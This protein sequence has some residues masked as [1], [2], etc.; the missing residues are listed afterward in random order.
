M[1]Y[2]EHV[3]NKGNAYRA[4][5][6]KGMATLIRIDKNG[7]KYWG[8]SKC[9]KCGGTGRLECYAHVEA[10]ICFLCDGSGIHEHRW[11]EY[12]PEYAQKLADR[13]VAKWRKEAPKHNEKLWKSIGL[14]EDGSAW[15]VIN[16]YAKAIDMKPQGAHWSPMLG[17]FF[18]EE[19][20]GTFFMTADDL[21]EYNTNFWWNFKADV[22]TL[23]DAKRAELAPKTE[24]EYIGKVGEKIEVEAV[25]EKK[26]TYETNYT[27]YGETNYI[28]KFKANGNTVVWKTSSWQDL[29]EGKTYK[30]KGTVKEHSEYRGDK[31]TVLTRCKITE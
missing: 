7:T 16:K 8:E 3:I 15:L 30:V 9:P 14:A 17:W 26:F 22:D 23:V 27:Y 29:E 11:K 5:R 24:S 31:Q 10:G 4:E 6:D 19:H 2:N 12:T 20:E 21:G 25:F 13:R 28:L 1:R 18:T